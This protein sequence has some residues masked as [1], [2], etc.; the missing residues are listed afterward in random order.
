M[1]RCGEH[2]ERDRR[3]RRYQERL[4]PYTCVR[5]FAVLRSRGQAEERHV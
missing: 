1:T 3:D 2:C 5:G 4:C